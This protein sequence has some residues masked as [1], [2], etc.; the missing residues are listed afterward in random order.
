[1]DSIFCAFEF[2]C[3]RARVLVCV[4]HFVRMCA[5]TFVYRN[6]RSNVCWCHCLV[7]WNPAR[8]PKL[9]HLSL[10]CN[11]GHSKNDIVTAVPRCSVH[12]I[13][14]QSPNEGKSHAVAFFTSPDDE[15]VGRAG[16]FHSLFSMFLQWKISFEVLTDC[17]Y[18]HSQRIVYSHATWHAAKVGSTVAE[19][20]SSCSPTASSWT[21]CEPYCKGT[22]F[23]RCFW[24]RRLTNHFVFHPKKIA[25]GQTQL[26]TAVQQ[27]NPQVQTL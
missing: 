18:L 1:M 8:K 9:K 6:R 25:G 15:G 13:Q 14:Y 17:C 26:V 10:T 4:C 24:W 7:K 3:T 11:G 2:V 19:S 12:V 5:S 27:M 20:K 22:A 21:E 16:L 23:D